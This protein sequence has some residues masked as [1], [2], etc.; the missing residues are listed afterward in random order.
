MSLNNLRI[1]EAANFNAKGSSNEQHLKVGQTWSNGKD[2]LI[3]MQ[4][5]GHHFKV[6]DK[7]GDI[8]TMNTHELHRKIAGDKY[9]LV[10]RGEH[11]KFIKALE[12]LL[13]SY[14][15]SKSTKLIILSV[16]HFLKSKGQTL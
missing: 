16:A 14:T 4:K 3:L 1:G 15:D 10:T 8:K 7:F 5:W 12:A 6:K 11:D 13:L 9:K 2:K